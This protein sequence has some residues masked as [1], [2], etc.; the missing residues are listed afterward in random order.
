MDQ[1]DDA[2]DHRRGISF[3]G[4]LEAQHLAA[5]AMDSSWLGV[6]N[7]RA[8]QDPRKGA[9][10][11]IH[12]SAL[13]MSLGM[14]FVP[15]SSSHNMNQS[16]TSMG[17]VMHSG[18]GVSVRGAAVD[19]SI[20]DEVGVDLEPIVIGGPGRHTRRRATARRRQTHR[21]QMGNPGGRRGAAKEE[22][23][24]ATG[25]MEGGD[26]GVSGWAE[27]YED[28]AGDSGGGDV[29]GD[30]DEGERWEEGES[31]QRTGC[32]RRHASENDVGRHR[33]RGEG[34]S[35]GERG[36]RLSRGRRRLFA[37]AYM[38]ERMHLRQAEQRD[39]VFGPSVIGVL[40][41]LGDLQSL[42]ALVIASPIISVAVYKYLHA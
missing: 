7:A 13:D 1:E 27:Q 28:D 32:S 36:W 21:S 14:G 4:G 22:V 17:S 24:S 15:S 23:L 33:E 29:D 38:R 42:G 30:E 39:V 10:R 12:P 26:A 2:C 9:N 19:A 40:E 16:T 35:G 11:L 5:S 34:G 41:N 8:L 18:V 25:D 20:M 37:R 3:V 6:R 31:A